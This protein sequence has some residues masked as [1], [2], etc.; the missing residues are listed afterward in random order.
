MEI[1]GQ[2]NKVLFNLYKYKS[3]RPGKQKSD[4]D[5][6][7]GKSVPLHKF[8]QTEQTKK[9][10]IVCVCVCVCVPYVYGIL[11]SHKKE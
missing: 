1:N 2:S 9:C 8:S 11:L 7:T 4:L 10:D 5:Y 3:S 6:H